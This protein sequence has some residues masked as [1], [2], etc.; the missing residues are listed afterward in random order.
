MK[1]VM[2]EWMHTPPRG[3]VGVRCHGMGLGRG[4]PLNLFLEMGVGRLPVLVK[5]LYQYSQK[6]SRVGCRALSG[7]YVGIQ[8][9]IVAPTGGERRFGCALGVWQELICSPPHHGTCDIPYHIPNLNHRPLWPQSLGLGPSHCYKKRQVCKRV[10]TLKI[11]HCFFPTQKP[12]GETNVVSKWPEK[13][14]V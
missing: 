11:C 10:S 4:F 9:I 2:Q 13:C 14:K 6:C 7:V 8:Q 12:L 1:S 3:Y 5:Y